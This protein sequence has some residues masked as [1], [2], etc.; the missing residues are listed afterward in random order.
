MRLLLQFLLHNFMK[1]LIFS[2]KMQHAQISPR[3]PQ[4]LE[5]AYSPVE[6]TKL[7]VENLASGCGKDVEC[8]GKKIA[9]DKN[10]KLFQNQDLV[11]VC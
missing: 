1:K 7:P 4:V 5:L 8:V 11:I 3:I 10:C 2:E 6:N 9:K